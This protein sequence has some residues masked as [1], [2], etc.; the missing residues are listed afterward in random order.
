LFE[1]KRQHLENTSKLKGFAMHTAAPDRYRGLLEREKLAGIPHE[2]GLDTK[3][4]SS[5]PKGFAMH[6]AAPDCYRGLLE[7][8]KLPRNCH[9]K[10]LNSKNQL[11]NLLCNEYRGSRL[12]SWAA[13]SGETS[14]KV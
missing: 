12:L 6:T 8:E 9:E 11:F 2:K 5:F 14:K 1:A 10:D 3:K 4:P 13:R 7:R